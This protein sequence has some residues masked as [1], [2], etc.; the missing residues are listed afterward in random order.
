MRNP[1]HSK[2]R[3]AR[4]PLRARLSRPRPVLWGGVVVGLIGVVSVWPGLG[5]FL[6]FCFGSL[7]L[8]LWLRRPGR[9]RRSREDDGNGF[10]DIWIT[11]P[12]AHSSHGSHAH[13]VG[14]TLA[15]GVDTGSDDSDGGDDGGGDGG[16]GGDGGGD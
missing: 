12:D 8:S 15:D 11:P 2:G 16:D 10:Q 7:A 14:G 1:T 4:V 5:L 9:P 3:P 13:S 6:G